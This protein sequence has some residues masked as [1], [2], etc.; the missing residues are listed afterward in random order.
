MTPFTE[1]SKIFEKGYNK[2]CEEVIKKELIAKNET[3]YM[4]DLSNQFLKFVNDEEDVDVWLFWA[5]ILK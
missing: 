1:S 3:R 2:S 4:T 5:F